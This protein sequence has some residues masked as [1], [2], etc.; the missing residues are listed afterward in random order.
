MVCFYKHTTTVMIRSIL[1]LFLLV[2]LPAAPAAFA[3]EGKAAPPE[4][5]A[6]ALQT[7]RVATYNVEN[8]FDAVINQPVNSVTGEPGDKVFSPESWRRWTQE[9]YRTKIANLAWVIGKMKPHILVVEEVENRGV[10]EDLARQVKRDSGW[11]IRHIAHVDSTDPR[12]I[13]VAILSQFPI[14]AVSHQPLAGR[15]GQLVAEIE[16]DGTR[17][18]V[19]ANHW[20]SQIGDMTTNIEIRSNEARRL[21]EEMLRRL[22]ANPNAVV[23]ACGDYNEDWDGPAIRAGLNPAHTRE[24]ALESLTLLPEKFLPYNLVCDIPE[25]KQGSF[26]YARTKRWNTFDGMFVLPAMLRPLSQ[27][28]P[29]WRV[30]SPADVMTFRLPEM[31]FGADKRPNS[32]RRVRAK[33]NEEQYYTNGYSDHFPVLAQF[34]RYSTPRKAPAKAKPDAAKPGTQ[35]PGARAN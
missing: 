17:V 5:Q 11:D 6:P 1:L 10:V 25:E 3:A 29:A 32:Y 27:P 18:I 2:L 19:I 31:E 21:R 4:T 13:D 14:R 16:L 8:L 35:K 12:G 9:R 26:Y 34:H 15:R 28:G 20:K 30:L 33:G 23:I 7:M 24:E 22:R